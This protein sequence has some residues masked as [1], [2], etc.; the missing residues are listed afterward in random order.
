M[1]HNL[2]RGLPGAIDFTPTTNLPRQIDHEQMSAKINIYIEKT[3]H[4]SP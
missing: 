4:A 2:G 1:A 3:N